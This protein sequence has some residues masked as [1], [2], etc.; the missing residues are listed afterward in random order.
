MTRFSTFYNSFSRKDPRLYTWNGTATFLSPF[1]PTIKFFYENFIPL[2]A[3]YSQYFN[4]VRTKV[5]EQF[6]RAETIEFKGTS[7]RYFEC[8][9]KKNISIIVRETNF[10]IWHDHFTFRTNENEYW[11]RNEFQKSG[12]I[13]F[14]IDIEMNFERL[15]E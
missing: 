10:E 3:Q 12:K 11:R 8:C 7:R 13:F 4:R 1:S 6:A 14:W 2:F 9:F 15:E 5:W